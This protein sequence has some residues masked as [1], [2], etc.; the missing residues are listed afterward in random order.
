MESFGFKIEN[1]PNNHMHADSKTP[2]VPRSVFAAG[3]VGRYPREGG[4]V[5]VT[6]RD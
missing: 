1:I 3:D 4:T 2:L 6:V 5:L